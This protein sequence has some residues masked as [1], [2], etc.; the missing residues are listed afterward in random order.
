MNSLPY[1]L[2]ETIVLHLGS[3]ELAPFATISATFQELIERRTFREL[4][5]RSTDIDQ[6]VAI[7]TGSRR[8]IL[9]LLDYFI[10]LPTVAERQR[11]SLGF[12][13]AIHDLFF[14]LS[15][16]DTGSSANPIKLS[17]SVVEDN[18]YPRIDYRRSILE[19][20]ALDSLQ[21]VPQIHTLCPD[22]G[23]CISDSSWINIASRLPNLQRLDVHLNHQR[24]GLDLD[25]RR[26]NR[27]SLAAALNNLHNTSHLVHITLFSPAIGW[28]RRFFRHTPN[29]LLPDDPTNDHLSFALNRLLRRSPN[30]RTFDIC[31]AISLS[32]ALFADDNTS[33]SSSFHR[34][35]RISISLAACAPDGTPYFHGNITSDPADIADYA[36]DGF[37]DSDDDG[38]PRPLYRWTGAAETFRTF[39][40]SA[41][42]FVSAARMPRLRA[43]S[44]QM[45]FHH[46][47]IVYAAPGVFYPACQWLGEEDPLGEG[48]LWLPRSYVDVTGL[49]GDGEGDKEVEEAWGGIREGGLVHWGSHVD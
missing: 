13:K 42:R 14:A 25:Q 18:I 46:C 17:I 44:L 26:R 45:Q 37:G 31:G 1:E 3:D 5:I 49:E 16:W 6:F 29:I 48:N 35:E 36:D 10:A 23:V 32:T 8:R 22:S 19:L 38:R 24:P 7:V 15:R 21:S 43:F 11:N 28:S 9:R 30:L 47:K 34:L 2:L 4:E 41:A 33:S 27:H 39:V 40:L 12:T 20:T